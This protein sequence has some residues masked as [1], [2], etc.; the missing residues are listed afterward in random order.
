MCDTGRRIHHTGEALHLEFRLFFSFLFIWPDFGVS[1][2]QPLPGILRGRHFIFWPLLQV[3]SLFRVPPNCF[4]RQSSIS[5]Q[6]PPFFLN[7]THFAGLSDQFLP[8]SSFFLYKR[9]F[10]GGGVETKQKKRRTGRRR[11]RRKKKKKERKKNVKRTLRSE[12]RHRQ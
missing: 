3:G 6:H 7:F 11:S 9:V 4:T 1:Y 12:H 2:K 10:R 8:P 5:P